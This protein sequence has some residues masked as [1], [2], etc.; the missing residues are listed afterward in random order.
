MHLFIIFLQFFTLLRA[1]TVQ[2]FNSCASQPD[3]C[4]C[5]VVKTPMDNMS[6]EISEVYKY[7]PLDC[8]EIWVAIGLEVV[9]YAKTAFSFSVGFKCRHC[10]VNL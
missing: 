6:K 8:P 4:Q 1:V 7:D 2:T 3:V 9:H 10:S 5:L